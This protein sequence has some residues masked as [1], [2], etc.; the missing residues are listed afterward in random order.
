MDESIIASCLG[1]G[2]AVLKSGMLIVN[3]LV[4]FRRLGAGRPTVTRRKRRRRRRAASVEAIRKACLE[5][6]GVV[7]GVS[8]STAGPFNLLPSRVGQAAVANAFS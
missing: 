8:V 1:Y 2:R 7:G 3:S 4:I 5:P 6:L